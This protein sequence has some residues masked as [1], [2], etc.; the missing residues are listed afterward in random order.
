MTVLPTRVLLVTGDPWVRA[1]LSATIA[2]D[3]QCTVVGEVDPT[4]TSAVADADIAIADMGEDAQEMDDRLDLPERLEMP[5]LALVPDAAT[6][7]QALAAGARG[8]LAR[9]VDGATLAAAVR[10][11]IRGLVVTDPDLAVPAAVTW[12]A[13]TGDLATPVEDLTPREREVLQLLA[14]G[15]PNRAIARRLGV[16]DHTVKFHMHAI[17]SKLDVHTRTEAVARAARLGLV[18]L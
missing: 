5:V 13:H 3:A 8:A 2:E 6:G 7:R 18:L 14:E 9:D 4:Q 1:H 17:F 16:S 11:I 10:A 15:L 12:D